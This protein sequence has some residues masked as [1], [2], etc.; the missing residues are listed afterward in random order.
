MTELSSI[1]QKIMDWDREDFD[2]L[3]YS[4]PQ[5]ELDYMSGLLDFMCGHYNNDFHYTFNK[6]YDPADIVYDFIRYLLC[7]CVGQGSYNS[8]KELFEIVL[9]M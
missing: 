4:F 3:A 6:N 5:S 8:S 2:D 9:A 1:K 7:E